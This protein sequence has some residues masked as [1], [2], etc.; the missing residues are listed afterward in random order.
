MTS[1]P[2]FSAEVLEGIAKILGDTKDGLT[3]GEIGHTLA[4][5][6]VAEFD[7]TATKWKRIHNA[8]AQAQN[9]HQDGRVVV[10]FI[11][12]S[13]SPSRWTDRA[14]QFEVLRE[15]LNV[16]LAFAGLQLEADGKL[17]RTV[18]AK[19]IREAEVRA[20][21]LRSTLASR[22]VHADVLSFCRA[23]LLEENY[24]HA[25]LEATKSVAEKIRRRSDLTTDGAELAQEAFGLG[26]TGP[27]LALSDLVT[28]TQ[29]S[30]QRGFTSLLVGLF[31]TF[32][33]PAA[34]APRIY[35]PMPEQDA[36]D[37]L[38]LLSLVHRKLD[39]A[40]RMQTGP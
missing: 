33:N 11:H 16:P 13:M 7:T 37:I 19:T 36:L 31:G 14:G 17:R 8:L 35:W 34:H 28:E 32:R 9:C 24:F 26:A 40:R 5:C 23:E 6:N 3:G 29:R 1:T 25:V 4:K 18:P 15:R 12:K 21:T 30:E 22:G 2:I 39:A 38:S 10:G 27:I 20:R